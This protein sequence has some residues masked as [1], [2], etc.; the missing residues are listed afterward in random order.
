MVAK[1]YVRIAGT[2]REIDD[3]WVK[4]AESWRRV[5]QTYV[6]TG[7]QWRT[8]F[9]RDYAVTISGEHQNLNLKSYLQTYTDWD[10]VTP[11]DFDVTLDSSARLRASSP[12]YY[13][14]YIDDFPANTVVR[15]YNYGYILGYG[16]SGGNGAG[17]FDS[18]AGNG[19]VGGNALY[20]NYPVQI[21][22]YGAIWSGGGGG[23][24]GAGCGY[25]YGWQ[26]GCFPQ[27]GT[28][29]CRRGPETWGA[30]GPS[31]GI[32]AGAQSGAGG[33]GGAQGHVSS[34]NC[35]EG[36]GSV[37][38]YT[39]AGGNGGYYGHTGHGGSQGDCFYNWGSQ[40]RTSPGAGGAGGFYVI[41]NAFA[42]WHV[43]GSTSGRVA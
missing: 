34:C 42:T 6:R 3:T 43:T 18:A 37:T 10:G 40:L 24:G 5:R 9:S 23:G 1:T 13:G 7:G 35:S 15:L 4:V 14:L 36:S 32:G 38:V 33:G 22:N 26:G 39:G 28:D 20:L 31:G 12:G 2:W 16:G 19:N 29:T 8:A 25:F 17:P 11:T 41:N 21:W 30:N 27:D